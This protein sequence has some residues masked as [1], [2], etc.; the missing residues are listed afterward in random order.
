MT[1]NSFVV[2]IDGK[3]TKFFSSSRGLRQGDLLSP[4]CLF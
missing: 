4:L 3:S 1:N 2:F